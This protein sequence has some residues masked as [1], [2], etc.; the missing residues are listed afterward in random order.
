MFKADATGRDLLGRIGMLLQQTDPILV[1]VGIAFLALLAFLALFNRRLALLAC[2]VTA[3]SLSA[4]AM[5]AVDTGATLVRWYIIV[6]LA[7]Q[8][9]RVRISPGPPLLM[10]L[11]FTVL[12]LSMT[13]FSHDFMWSAQ[14]GL[15]LLT[16]TVAGLA[17]GDAVDSRPKVR[18]VFAFF[19][20]PSVLWTVLGLTMLPQLLAG[21][22]GH[23]TRFGGAYG[24]PAIFVQIGGLLLPF[25]LWGALQPTFK[26]YWRLLYGAVFCGILVLLVASSQRSGLFAGGI[27]CIPLMARRRFTHLLIP[28]FLFLLTAGILFQLAQVNEAQTEFTIKRLTGTETTGRY[29]LW[30][31]TIA[32]IMESPFIGHGLGSDRWLVDGHRPHNWYLTVWYS[33][34]I[35]GLLLLLALLAVACWYALRIARTR[36]DL[37]MSNFGRLVL[38]QLLGIMASGLVTTQ[39]SPSNLLTIVLI[40]MLALCERLTRVIEQEFAQAHQNALLYAYYYQPEL[41]GYPHPQQVP[42]G[43]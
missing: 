35:F 14:V 4:P 26:K 43:H 9:F 38:G 10:Y 5:P 30:L 22:M 21:D 6:L 36:N 16:T 25:A 2:L 17:L 27:A 7:L 11:A 18:Q 32:M 15:L 42:A 28:G 37:E 8:V 1:M 3:A 19:A 24:N 23:A 31:T 34:G 20:V 33:T 39:S 12:S 13:V 40:L 29:E 41:L